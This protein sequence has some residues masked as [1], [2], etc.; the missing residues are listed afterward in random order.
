[1][2][3]FVELLDPMT[4]DEGR[5]FTRAGHYI[6]RADSGG[7]ARQPYHE[8]SGDRVRPRH[9]GRIAFRMIGRFRRKRNPFDSNRTPTFE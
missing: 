2:S 8:R 6:A 1:M 4:A 5:T 7:S 9:G 3:T